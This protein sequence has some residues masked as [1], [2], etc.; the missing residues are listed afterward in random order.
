MGA[1]NGRHEL[2]D[3]VT[4]SQGKKLFSGKQKKYPDGL[5]FGTNYKIKRINRCLDGAYSWDDVFLEG[6][7]KAFCEFDLDTV[8][9]G[10]K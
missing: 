1:D 9:R 4:P 10:K 6:F 3:I 5:V 8:E 2:G 7:E